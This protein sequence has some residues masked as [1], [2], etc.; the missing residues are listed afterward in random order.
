MKEIPLD[1]TVI[2]LD[3]ECGKSSHVIIE[4]NSQQVTHLVVKSSNFL[5]SHKYLVPIGAVITTNSEAIELS[6][7]KKELAAMPSFT[8]MRFLNPNTAKFEPLENFDEESIYQS[9]SHLMWSDLMWSDPLYGESTLSMPIE[10]ELI[11]DGEIAIHRGASIEATDGHI[12]KVEGFSIDPEDKHLTHLVLQAGHFW[13][14]K[15]LTIPLSAI[16]RMDEEYIYLKL[17]KRAVKSLSVSK[18]S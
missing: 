8:E 6:C 2:C 7:T 9:S 3:G 13:H 5:E 15:E 11:P 18:P 10:T 12:G 17:D 16:A 4:N 1:A 14:K